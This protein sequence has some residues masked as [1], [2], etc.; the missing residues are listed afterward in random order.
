MPITVIATWV[1]KESEEAAVERLLRDNAVATNAEPGC[2]EFTVLRSHDEPRTFVLYERYDD[3]AAFQAHRESAH[4]KKY[5]LDDAV[6]NGRLEQ[7][8][9]KFY[10]PL[11]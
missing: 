7:R 4:F 6:A 1:A 11:D 9:A 5:V 8:F 3:E 2:R 10:E